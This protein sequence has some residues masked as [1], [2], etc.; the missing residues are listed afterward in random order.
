MFAAIYACFELG[1]VVARYQTRHLEENPGRTFAAV[2]GSIF[3][4]MSLLLAFT[5]SSTAA[6]FESRRQLT[7][8][9]ANAIEIA[10]MRSRLL[11][12]QYQ[13]AMNEKLRQY[14]DSRVLFYKNMPDKN[15]ALLQMDR[16]IGLQDE[17]WEAGVVGT[18]GSSPAVISL[19]LSS[20]N[21]MTDLTDDSLMLAQTHVPGLIQMLLIALP[22]IC[23]VL[24]GFEASQLKSR[25]WLPM[26]LF[27]L[28][29]S[30]TVMVIF[31][32]DYPRI[33]LIRLDF[34]DQVL[35]DLQSRM[36]VK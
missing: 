18:A 10:W 20:L 36:Q 11:P 17:L 7:V 14:L 23:A 5:F 32:L 1:K 4:L 27:A 22:L 16:S 33:G 28:M 26:L 29:A 25:Y 21:T 31:D 24:A 34:H 8:H 3:G 19:V 13:P 30:L 2:E 6:R 9:E 15:A 12:P 35:I